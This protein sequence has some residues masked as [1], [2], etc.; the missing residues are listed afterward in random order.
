[1]E[2]HVPIRFRSVTYTLNLVVVVVAVEVGGELISTDFA[3][4]VNT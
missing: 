3:A 1:M 2:K 4:R